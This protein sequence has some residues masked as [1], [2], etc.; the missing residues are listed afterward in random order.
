MQYCFLCNGP[1]TCLTC[2]LGEVV[3]GGCSTMPGC[4]QVEQIPTT[5]GME[6]SCL[7][8]DEPEFDL[9]STGNI[10]TCRVGDLVGSHCTSVSGCLS[11]VKVAGVVECVFCDISRHF[12]L[13][14]LSKICLCS[15]GYEPLNSTCQD[16]CGDGRVITSE[17]DDGNLEN[18]DGCSSS[19]EVET[20]YRCSTDS[21]SVCGF[22]GPIY[23]VTLTETQRAASENRGIFTFAFDPA[24]P[25]LARF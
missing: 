9:N 1:S 14:A 15:D 24:L 5:N 11:T 22:V 18:G 13:D 16:I 4:T 25:P 7:A 6:S 21:P 3:T 23:G 8:C 20:Y 10:C 17:C 2:F 12:F 19:C